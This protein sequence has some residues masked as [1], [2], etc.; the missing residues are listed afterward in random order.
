M[1][2]RVSSDL[3]KP[4]YWDGKG[5]QVHECVSFQLRRRLFLL[6]VTWFAFPF[7][8]GSKTIHGFAAQLERQGIQ[9]ARHLWV[10]L[11]GFQ[12]AKRVC[13][14]IPRL[15]DI[16][17]I[18]APSWSNHHVCG[19]AISWIR[20]DALDR[21]E[22]NYNPNLATLH[23]LSTFLYTWDAFFGTYFL[24]QSGDANR[25]S[26]LPKCGLYILS[27]SGNV[28][29]LV[30][31]KPSRL[32]WIRKHDQAKNPEKSQWEFQDLKMKLLCGPTEIHMNSIFSGEIR[33][34]NEFKFYIHIYK[35]FFIHRISPQK[36]AIETAAM[37]WSVAPRCFPLR[38]RWTVFGGAPFTAR[39]AGRMQA[40]PWA[41]NRGG[42]R[43]PIW[44]SMEIYENL[45]W[46]N[47]VMYATKIR[48]WFVSKLV[49]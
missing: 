30:Q 9:R 40:V 20:L 12:I 2:R 24:L 18:R 35:P 22:E 32:G 37:T 5:R 6:L 31:H 8:L 11:C 3:I 47:V 16:P 34:M 48:F 10:V 33:T 26:F 27:N 46:C 13:P 49:G 23:F 41:Q 14:T 1:R 4:I 39:P 29:L 28:F 42:R 43:K 36:A 45:W 25:A 38:R 44:K 21:H 7:F 19:R 17:K 15:G